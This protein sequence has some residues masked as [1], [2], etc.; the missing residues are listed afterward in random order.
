MER[1]WR[2]HEARRSKDENARMIA[3]PLGA[4]KDDATETTE[5]TRPF[6]AIVAY[7]TAPGNACLAPILH[8]PG[9]PAFVQPDVSPNRL[10]DAMKRRVTLF[11][12]GGPLA[13]PLRKRRKA[14]EV[15]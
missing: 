4:V 6:P 2:P 1:L 14:L 15:C 5:T 11:A 10:S 12:C 8:R 9:S 13:D 7:H 3:A